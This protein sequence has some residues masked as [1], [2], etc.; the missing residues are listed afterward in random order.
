MKQWNQQNG[1]PASVSTS[2]AQP[3]QVD[4][5]MFE[6]PLQLQITTNEM[7]SKTIAM[8]EIDSLIA[9]ITTRLS[10][11][12]EQISQLSKEMLDGNNYQHL[13]L[14]DVNDTALLQA[15][16]VQEALLRSQTA[17][18]PT[19]TL[20]TDTISVTGISL[21]FLNFAELQQIATQYQNEDKLLPTAIAGLESEIRELKSDLE[22]GASKTARTCC[23]HDV[24][25]LRLRQ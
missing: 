3:I 12:N 6:T 14:S 15:I 16:R 5:Q 9:V 11:L 4:M 17:T 13:T 1:N 7:M 19:K 2:I 21:P 10:E 20:P 24:P 25:G 22:F 8:N 18:Q 23:K